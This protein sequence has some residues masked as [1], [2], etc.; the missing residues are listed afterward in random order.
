MHS[1]DKALKSLCIFSSSFFTASGLLVP[2]MIH[3][4][5]SQFLS[6]ANELRHCQLLGATGSSGQ[7]PPALPQP[8][9]AGTPLGLG[10]QPG[11]NPSASRSLV[12]TPPAPLRGAPRNRPAPLGPAGSGRGAHYAGRSLPLPRGPATPVVTSQPGQKLQRWLP[13]PH[14]IADAISRVA[15]NSERGRDTSA[16]LPGTTATAPAV[17]NPGRQASGRAWPGR[18]RGRGHAPGRLRAGGGASASE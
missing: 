7:A 9:S 5:P 14:R 18:G 1:R 6:G 13:K 8:G 12:A 10:C 11:A 16:A 2:D 15:H 17:A 4:V 3:Q